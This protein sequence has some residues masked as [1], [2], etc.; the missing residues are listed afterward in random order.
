MSVNERCFKVGGVEI[1]RAALSASTWLNAFSGSNLIGWLALHVNAQCRSWQMWQVII[2]HLNIHPMLWDQRLT[3]WMAA[4]VVELPAKSLRQKNTPPWLTASQ[5]AVDSA[6]G[7]RN[8]GL[9]TICVVKQSK[10]YRHQHTVRLPDRLAGQ[11]AYLLLG[12]RPSSF[13]SGLRDSI[14]SSPLVCRWWQTKSG[15]EPPRATHN[16]SGDIFRWR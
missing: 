12:V 3:N 4:F 16:P 10:E 6:D 8:L 7:D 9:E 11:A 2:H 14:S 1:Q 5:C 15:K 13:S